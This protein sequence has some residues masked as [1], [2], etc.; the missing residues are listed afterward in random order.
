MGKLHS[1]FSTFCFDMFFFFT[2]QV[3]TFQNI[4]ADFPCY[5]TLIHHLSYCHIVSLVQ[6]TKLEALEYH[7]DNV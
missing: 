5:S 1:V 2:M 4:F 3:R 6:V 7:G